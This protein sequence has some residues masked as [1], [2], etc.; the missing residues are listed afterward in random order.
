MR[1]DQGDNMHQLKTYS[2]FRRMIMIL[3][4]LGL[5]MGSALPLVADDEGPSEEEVAEPTFFKDDKDGGDDPWNGGC[6]WHYRDKVCSAAKMIFSGDYCDGDVLYEWTNR[7]CHDAEE[8]KRR[9]NCAAECEKKG[10]TGTCV[11]LR[12]DCGR[13]ADSAKCECKEESN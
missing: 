2:S 5:W 13:G 1:C 3:F 7:H 8:D 4:F 9:Y 12:N 6:H 10:A 11:T